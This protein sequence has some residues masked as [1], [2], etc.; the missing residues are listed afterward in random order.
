MRQRG[1]GDFTDLDEARALPEPGLPREAVRLHVCHDPLEVQVEPEL[2][3]PVPAQRHLFSL[4]P[5][6]KAETSPICQYLC[7]IDSLL[8]W[9][10][11]SKFHPFPVNK[12]FC[13][14]L[15]LNGK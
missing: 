5:K 9:I 4:S 7:V 12:L 13:H 1:R 14:V 2:P 10:S 11:G 3:H 8:S 15:E 6:A